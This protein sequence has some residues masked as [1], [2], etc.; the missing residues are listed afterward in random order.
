MAQEK[1]ED[2]EM[3][4]VFEMK[5]NIPPERFSAHMEFMKN[6]YEQEKGDNV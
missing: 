3:R 5:R 4:S 1:F 2:P 6:L